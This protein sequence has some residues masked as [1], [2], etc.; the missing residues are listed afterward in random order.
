MA[1]GINDE[2]LFRH[3][4]RV[5]QNT[6]DG[7]QKFGDVTVLAEAAERMNWPGAPEIGSAIAVILRDVVAKEKTGTAS[8]HYRNVRHR[9]IAGLARI[10]H[11]AGLTAAESHKRL[12]EIYGTMTPDNVRKIVERASEEKEADK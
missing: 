10:H 7:R 5:Y 9:E 6:I 12:E 1:D 2:E 11:Q 3:L 8:K 4:W